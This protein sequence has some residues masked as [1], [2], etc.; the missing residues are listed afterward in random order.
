MEEEWKQVPDSNFSH[1]YEISNYG[2][3]KRESKIL[4]QFKKGGDGYWMIKL[5]NKKIRKN[6]LVH[7]LVALAF[8]TRVSEDNIVNHIDSNPLNNIFT[9]LEWTTTQGNLEHQ[10]INKNFA[11]GNT[12]WNYKIDP[13]K[14][15]ELRKSG[16][17]YKQI[18]EHFGCSG[19]AVGYCLERNGFP[20]D[21]QIKSLSPEDIK[22]AGNMRMHGKTF[23]EIGKYF[24]VSKFC[25]ADNLRINNIINPHAKTFKKKVNPETAIQMFNGGK[26]LTQIAVFFNVR[27]SVIHYHLKKNK[28]I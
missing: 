10:R 27:P 7:R 26:S 11:K 24:N 8:V 21:G 9:N 1:I 17:T 14:A 5:S 13:E 25:I 23:S 18:G 2:R 3:I 28:I 6:F 16:L 4:A 20:I 12:N 15:I 22:I 19:E